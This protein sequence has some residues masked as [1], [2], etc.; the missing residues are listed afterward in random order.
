MRM[1]STWGYP[2]VVTIDLAR[3]PDYARV[4]QNL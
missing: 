3:M 4:V 1:T 2:D